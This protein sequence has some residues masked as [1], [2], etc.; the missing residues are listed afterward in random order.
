M[1]ISAYFYIRI[2]FFRLVK[3]R[4]KNHD[5]PGMSS[6]CFEGH[7]LYV[8]EICAGVRNVYQRK[9]TQPWWVGV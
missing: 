4:N 3:V 1:T 7:T 5:T 9:F 8:F 2:S 6:N